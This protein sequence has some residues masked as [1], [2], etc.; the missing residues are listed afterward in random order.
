MIVALH[1]HNIGESLMKTALVGLMLLSSVPFAQASTH[2]FNC[3]LDDADKRDVVLTATAMSVNELVN[4][5][6]FS[7]LRDSMTGVSDPWEMSP[8]EG[9]RFYFH[10][11]NSSSF[12]LI[13]D[14][15]MTTLMNS[16]KPMVFDAQGI[17]E[18][19]ERGGS[20]EISDL[21]CV[22]NN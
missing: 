1:K 10:N 18:Q 19:Y 6:Y 20:Q 21:T 2:T 22:S 17:F 5:R 14:A 11:G 3:F 15:T 13:P 4:V 16:D 12:I 7:T 8:Q 9:T